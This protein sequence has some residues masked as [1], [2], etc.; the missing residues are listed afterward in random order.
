MTNTQSKGGSAQSVPSVTFC[1][2]CG[3]PLG[4]HAASLAANP[5]V[6][7]CPECGFKLNGDNTCPNRS[8]PYYA[9]V[10]AGIPS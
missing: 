2:E 9:T 4:G 10:P 6:K 5:S 3:S 7:F 1:T 8:C